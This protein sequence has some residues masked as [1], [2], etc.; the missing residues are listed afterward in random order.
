[1]RFKVPQNIDMPDRVLG[2]LT[3]VQFVYAVVGFGGAYAIYNSFPAPIG[4]IF[5]LPIAGITFCVIFIKI[6]ERP[7]THFLL[8]LLNFI[9]RPKV[10][11]WQKT[12]TMDNLTIQ[13]Y[14]PVKKDSQTVAHK[15]LSEEDVD[16][17]AKQ[18]DYDISK[19]KQK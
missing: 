18:L 3:L 13:I 15:E 9:A 1:M 17:L 16:K 2:P 7:F 19:I 10:R 8:S 12:Q 5:A 14:K 6:N 4:L 11:T